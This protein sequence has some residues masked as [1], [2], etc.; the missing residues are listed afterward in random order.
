QALGNLVENA[1]RHGGGEVR[2]SAHRA[3][4]GAVELHVS[5]RGP[6]FEDGFLDRAFDR[7]SR[8]D[9]GRTGGG[10]GLG[11]AIVDAIA[12]AHGGA[13]GAGRSEGQT[14]VWNVLPSAADGSTSGPAERPTSFMKVCGSSTPTRGPPGP[15]RPSV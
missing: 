9:E 3:V 5:D 4:G 7:F 15:V 13:A 14:H 2:I 1:L 8:T 6:G 12:R 11:L 10:A